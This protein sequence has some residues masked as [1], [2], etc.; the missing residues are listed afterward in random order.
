VGK[1][2]AIIGNVGVGKTTLA[3]IL[4]DWLPAQAWLEQHAERPY[5][6]Q[7]AS[8]LKT[9]ALQNQV[10]YL[11]FRGGQEAQGRRSPLAGIFDGGMDLDFELFTRLFFQRGYLKQAEF[12]VCERLYR[13]LRLTLPD[14]DLIINLKAPL[15]LLK[16]RMQVRRRQLEAVK[17]DDL[18]VIQLLIDDW[19][20]RLEN[21]TVFDV[22][23]GADDPTYSATLARL[24]ELIR[25]HLERPPVL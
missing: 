6:M 11:L 19:R 5:Q 13:A 1:L 4:A 10:D 12:E 16:R 8:E 2:I 22:D 3:R 17:P 24:G 18:P 20:R 23:A 25:G 7:F 15:P 14:P 9:D 21:A